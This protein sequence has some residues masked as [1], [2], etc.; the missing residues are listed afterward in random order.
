MG[1]DRFLDLEADDTDQEE[2]EEDRD[3]VEMEGF[4]K[5]Y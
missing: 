3:G 5:F 4:S 2:D 1:V